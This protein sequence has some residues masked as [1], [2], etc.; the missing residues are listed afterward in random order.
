LHAAVNPFACRMTSARCNFAQT[1]HAG[2]PGLQCADID[3]PRITGIA[4]AIGTVGTTVTVSGEWRDGSHVRANCC[5]HTYGP[6]PVYALNAYSCYNQATVISGGQILC[7][8]PE[9]E[10]TVAG[11]PDAAVGDTVAVTV[12]VWHLLSNDRANTWRCFSNANNDPASVVLGNFTYRA[13]TT[14]PTTSTPTAVP[15]SSAPTT[16]Y[17]TPAPTPEPGVCV[18]PSCSNLT[19]PP[20]STVIYQTRVGLCR[21]TAWLR[22]KGWC[23]LPR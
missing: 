9:V 5:W 17:P 16:G 15:T 4:P 10:S 22:N 3:R 12:T 7:E 18:H 1:P 2:P 6:P 8:V 11:H 14:A 20:L 23:A 19:P 13:P 21:M